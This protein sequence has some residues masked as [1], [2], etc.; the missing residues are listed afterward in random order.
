MIQLFLIAALI[1]FAG[2]SLV[3]LARDLR[4]PPHSFQ[5]SEERLATGRRR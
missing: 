2:L 4:H 5:T 1:A 3:N